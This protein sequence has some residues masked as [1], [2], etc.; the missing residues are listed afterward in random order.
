VVE[1]LET[2]GLIE[3]AQIL[4]ADLGQGYAFARPMPASALRGWLA[5]FDSKWDVTQPVTALGTLAATLLWEER[6]DAL[7]GDPVFWRR[8]A[9]TNDAPGAYLQHG[10][11]ASAALIE[12]H[13]RMHA[14]SIGGPKDPVYRRAR[15]AYIAQ[16]IHCVNAEERRGGRMLPDVA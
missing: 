4:G 14:A 13:A 16:L 1:G 6:F 15:E 3:A 12:S 8:H 7:P 10:N 9:E 11:P 5:G 2:P